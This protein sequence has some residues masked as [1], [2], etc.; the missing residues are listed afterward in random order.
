MEETRYI[1]QF[2]DLNDW[3]KQ[4]LTYIGIQLVFLINI[5]QTHLEI[6]YNNFYKNNDSF[7]KCVDAIEDNAYYLKKLTVPYYIEPPFSYFKVCYKDNTYKE[8]YM[9]V[10]S[11]LY[12]TKTASTLVGL[13]SVYNNFF[14][15]V[16]PIIKK[17]E[18]EY[19]VLLHYRNMTDDCIISRLITND[20][21]YDEYNIVCDTVPTRNYFLSIEYH[22]PHMKNT[23]SLN[24]DK[25]YLIAGNELFSPCF[26][27]KCLN[28]QK[29]SYVFDADYKLV[30]LDSD[31]NTTTLTCN[32]YMRLSNVK[33]E[34]IEVKSNIKTD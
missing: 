15:I 7:H 26:V 6:N 28:Y 18:L 17:N 14:S 32:Q 33:Y 23:I 16:K 30:I 1:E 12:E 24:L 27:L 10:D 9:N 21:A 19:L 31:I 29:E 11:I 8:E 4:Y 22:H 13:V 3:L 2:N 34:V 5:L 25:R 20:E